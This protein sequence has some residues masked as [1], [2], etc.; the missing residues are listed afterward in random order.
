M[1]GDLSVACDLPV[2]RKNGTVYYADIKIE[3]VKINGL[4]YLVGIFIDITERKRAEAERLKLELQIQQAQKLESLGVLA[5]G[6]AHDF[7]NLLG[8]IFGYIDLAYLDTQDPVVSGYLAKAQ[9]TMA[10]A[11]SLTQQLLTFAKGGAPMRKIGRLFPFIEEAA[12]FALSGSNIAC[13]FTIPDDLWLCDFDENQIGQVIDNLIINAKQAMPMGGAIEIA[14]QNVLLQ[15]H[16][17]ASLAKG[18]YVKLSIKD[19][20][21]G[22]PQEH[23][24]HIFD[25]FFTTKI[26]GHGLGLA[27]SY[28][29]VKR[30]DG[31][32]TVD[33]EPGKGT[34]FHLFLPAAPDNAA[35]APTVNGNSISVNTNRSCGRVLLMDDEEV[36]RD[37]VSNMLKALGYSVVCTANGQEALAVFAAETKGGRPFTAVMLDLTVPGG[38]GGKEATAMLRQWNSDIPVFVI[39]GYA[40]DPIMAAPG[41][42]GFT[43]SISKPFQTA[44][45]ANLLHQHLPK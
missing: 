31:C 45:L 43:A 26:N 39:S 35:A 25:P 21:S 5:G 41:N 8:G 37:T 14:A 24:P 3:L 9:K 10:R 18:R 27:I 20:G 19:N 11:R 28:S 4:E 40:E 13:R 6:I 12:K 7:N 1:N 29:I 22:I 42:F 16:E 17:Y 23:L 33:A 36:I 38:M 15:T 2:L 30:H 44:D 34:T 32:I